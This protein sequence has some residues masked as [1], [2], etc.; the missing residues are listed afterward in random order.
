MFVSSHFSVLETQFLAVSPLFLFHILSLPCKVG[1]VLVMEQKGHSHR[2]CGAKHER[3]TENHNEK[4]WP[5]YREPCHSGEW[6]LMRQ[7]PSSDG[8]KGTDSVGKGTGSRVRGP[9]GAGS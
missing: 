4:P 1:L 5:F 2:C 6:E 7:S 3:D 8:A 9:G